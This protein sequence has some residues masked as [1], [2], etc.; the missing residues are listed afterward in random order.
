MNSLPSQALCNAERPFQHPAP[1]KWRRVRFQDI[2]RMV[3]SKGWRWERASDGR[4][5]LSPRGEPWDFRTT[6][7]GLEI[8][9]SVRRWLERLIP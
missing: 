4:I 1:P 3:V 6:R 8:R 7:Q 5:L 9:R 2:T